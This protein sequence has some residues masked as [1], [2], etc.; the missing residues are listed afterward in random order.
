MWEHPLTGQHLRQLASDGGAGD[1]PRHIDL[2]ELMR[3]V[4]AHC[5]RLRIVPPQSKRLACDDVGI[6]AM[7][8]LDDIA[9][10]VSEML[11][12]VNSAS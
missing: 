8:S 3:Q 2:D 11:R 6:G 4:N 12:T 7:A 1:L 9:A 10:A 5:S